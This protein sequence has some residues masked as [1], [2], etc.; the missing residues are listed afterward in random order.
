MTPNSSISGN[1]N[2]TIQDVTDSI[3]TV[4]V[5]GEIQE[6]QNQLQALIALVR[7]QQGHSIQYADKI[8]NIAHITEA[9]FGLV[10]GK[11]AFNE[12]LTQQLI[13]AIQPC[14][15]SAQK[16]LQHVAD[17]PA[18]QSQTSISDKAREILA[19]SFVG[20][21]GI[22][23]SKLMAIGKENFSETKHRKYIEKCIDITQRS[24]DL[25]CFTLLSRWW[26]AQKQ[27]R[28][29]L[30]DADAAVL[31]ARLDSSFAPSI[32]QQ[33]ELLQNLHRLFVQHNIAFPIPELAGMGDALQ[34]GS[35]L[36]TTCASL[37]ALHEKLDKGRYDLLDCDAAE[38]QLADL[39]SSFSFLACYRMASIKRIGYQQI[40]NAEA[41]YLHRYAAL[42]IDS[43]ANIDAEKINYTP[44]T[45]HTDAVLLYQGDHYRQNINLFP[46]VIDYNA[47]TFEQGAKICFY[48]ARDMHDDQRLEFLFLE[49]NSSV[50]LECKGILKP[51][52]VMN[53]LM[54]RDADRIVLNLDSVVEQFQIARRAILGEND[55]HHELDHLN[56]GTL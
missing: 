17:V 15:V 10:T 44:E 7:S 8:Y 53:E 39:L 24:F 56:G 34:A 36:H 16:F 55:L 13:A 45:T 42:G 37:H 3:I 32:V 35:A 28:V 19:Y 9:N 11:R 31:R 54:M 43:K 48:R 1:H 2:I 26:D 23:L 14:S 21:I 5:N 38:T 49:D 27:H 41:N 33:F 51:D 25:I 22:Q 40:R 50:Y 6:I 20:A 12:T 47:L 52:T 30:S 46:F 18:W 4:N 29:T